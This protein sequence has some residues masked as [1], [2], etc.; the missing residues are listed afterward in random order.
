[1][2]DPSII[3]TENTK[4]SGEVEKNI[5]RTEEEWKENEPPKIDVVRKATERL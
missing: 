2:R 5:E 1:M 4:E 3:G